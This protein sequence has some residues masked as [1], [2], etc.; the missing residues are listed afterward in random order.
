MGELQS[1]T[2]TF[3]LLGEHVKSQCATKDVR[4][5]KT[6]GVGEGFEAL[7][8]LVADADLKARG[9]HGDAR[10]IRQLYGRL[11]DHALKADAPPAP[12][13]PPPASVFSTALA[14][15]LKNL[16]GAE[17]G[18]GQSLEQLGIAGAAG[19][20]AELLQ[21]QALSCIPVRMAWNWILQTYS[22]L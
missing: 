10:E 16:A 13:N 1:R 12:R 6:L 7:V 11:P 9:G 5:G 2:S 14:Q 4:F 18:R 17:I 19:C 8:D 15:G 3:L 22:L 20:F 21:R